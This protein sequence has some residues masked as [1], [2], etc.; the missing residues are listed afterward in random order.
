M[1]PNTDRP[2]RWTLRALLEATLAA[3]TLLA[4]SFAVTA[5]PAP[6]SPQPTP[7]VRLYVFD[8]GWLKSANP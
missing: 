5:Q 2:R 4:A 1:R 6:P 8:L 3:A 7:A